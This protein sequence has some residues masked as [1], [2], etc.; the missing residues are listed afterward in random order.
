[1][2]A[3]GSKN[4]VQKRRRVLWAK[5]HLKW[6]VSKC[7]RALWSNEPKFDILVGNYGRRVGVHNWAKE[8]G[9]KRM[10]TFQRVISIQFK[11]Q[12]L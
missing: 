7:K 8:D 11:T 4:M 10:E 2:A 5:A 3:D 6:I 12:H 9:L 1:M